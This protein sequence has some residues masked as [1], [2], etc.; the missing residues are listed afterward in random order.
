MSAIE[1]RPGEERDL[2]ALTNLYNYYVENTPITF[3]VET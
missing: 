1:I 3:D 2:P